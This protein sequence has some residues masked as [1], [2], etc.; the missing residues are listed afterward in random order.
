MFSYDANAAIQT[1]KSWEARALNKVPCLL[2]FIHRMKNKT[3]NY[4]VF[5][6]FST[7]ETK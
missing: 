3:E 4:I 7:L 5:P 2:L 1:K 6:L